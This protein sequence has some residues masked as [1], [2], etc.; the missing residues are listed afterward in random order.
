MSEEREVLDWARYG[1]AAREL[2]QIVADDDYQPDII[3]AIGES[4]SAAA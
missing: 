2:A 4:A 3:L 1:T